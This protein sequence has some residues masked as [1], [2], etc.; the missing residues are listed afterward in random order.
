MQDI[1]TAGWVL[2][3]KLDKE[4]EDCVDDVIEQRRPCG[5]ARDQ[6]AGHRC[7]RLQGSKVFAAPHLLVD[8][9]PVTILDAL[10]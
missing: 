2:H 4:L 3:L 5:R 7:P 1:R 9:G 8:F 6:N 10:L